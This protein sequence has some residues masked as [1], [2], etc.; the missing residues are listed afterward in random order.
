MHR[1]GGAFFAEKFKFQFIVL[2][3]S[4]QL[5]NNYHCHCEAAFAAVAISW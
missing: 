3:E 1:F 2:F 5:G 4:T